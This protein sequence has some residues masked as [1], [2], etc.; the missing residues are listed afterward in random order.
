MSSPREDIPSN[1]SNTSPREVSNI[2]NNDAGSALDMLSSAASIRHNAI[3]SALPV[4]HT[5]TRP[6]SSIT[7]STPN[8]DNLSPVNRL[9]FREI[10]IPTSEWEMRIQDEGVAGFQNLYKLYGY[11]MFG[12]TYMFHSLYVLWVIKVD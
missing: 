9:P 7:V 1:L 12:K 5:P 2:D 10:C 6:P 4:P 8:T 3:K 11:D